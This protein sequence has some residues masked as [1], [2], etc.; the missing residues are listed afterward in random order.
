MDYIYKVE[1]GH[2]TLGVICNL[3]LQSLWIGWTFVSHS[4][5]IK[6][7]I[8]KKRKYYFTYTLIFK[9][10]TLESSYILEIVYEIIL[11]FSY[12]YGCYLFQ[13]DCD[14]LQ[15]GYKISQ[16]IFKKSYLYCSVSADNSLYIN[17]LFNIHIQCTVTL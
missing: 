4:E 8:L 12:R 7:S 10:N 11:G 15:V 9:L 2:N 17:M 16:K 14:F 3:V 6:Q 1:R 13:S 5:I